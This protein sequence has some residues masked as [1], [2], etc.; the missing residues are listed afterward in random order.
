MPFVAA[1][2]VVPL[3]AGGVLAP[4]QADAQIRRSTNI[5]AG[6]FIEAPRAVRRS[7]SE[8]EK[9]IQDGNYG[10]AIIQLG[11][12][13]TGAA[14][15]A[16]IS[17]QDFILPKD[18]QATSRVIQGGMVRQVRQMIGSLPADGRRAYRERYGAEARAGLEEALAA[19]D[20]HA[21]AE[22]RRK[23]F[24]T[25]AGYRASGRLARRAWSRGRALQCSF[26]LDD[27]VT[28]PDA[29]ELL[30][31][32]VVWMHAAACAAAGREIEQPEALERHP[33]TPEMV[34]G[35]V[36]ERPKLDTAADPK[37]ALADWLRQHFAGGKLLRR[38]GIE[39]A[40]FL[41]TPD[42]NGTDSGELPLSSEEWRARTVART[43][44]EKIVNDVVQRFATMGRSP[45]PT[46]MPIA[47][48]GQVLMRTTERLVGINAENGKS[49]WSFPWQ[50][51][52]ENSMEDSSGYASE[53]DEDSGEA[54]LF[55]QRIWYD[56]PYGQ[57][58]SDGK[59]VF[60]IDGLG[61]LRSQPRNIW[62][63]RTINVR[64]EGN[65][66]V[67]LELATEGKLLWQVGRDGPESHPLQDAFF[68]GPPLQV[69]GR[70]YVL[71][72]S[73]GDIALFCLRPVDGE[74]L[75]KQDLVSVE[76]GGVAADPTRRLAG[77]IPTF[78][79]GVMI[80]PTGAGAI[81][82]LDLADRRIRWA[83]Q[84]G[85]DDMLQAYRGRQRLQPL[86][87]Y[88]S[89]WDAPVAIAQGTTVLYPSIERD[90]LYG[91]N[92]IDGKTKFP[93][94]TRNQFRYLAGMRD[95][96]FLLVSPDGVSAYDA[97]NGTRL[98]STKPAELGGGRICG[99]GVFGKNSYIIPTDAP[100]LIEVSLDD[101]VVV[102][103]R[104]TEFPLGNLIAFDGRLIAQGP[105][106]LT[107]ALG[108]A[109]L[110]PRVQKLLEISE[111]DFDALLLKS[112]LLLQRDQR[113]EAIDVLAKARALRPG[114]IVVHLRS[115]TAMLAAMRD[116]PT[117]DPELMKK[118]DSMIVQEDQRREFI[119]LRVRADLDAGQ[120][121]AAVQSLVQLAT[122]ISKKNVNETIAAGIAARGDR[123]R[124]LA[125]GQDLLSEPGDPPERGD[126][127]V[128]GDAS[129]PGDAS[130]S[131]RPSPRYR[132]LDR[133][134]TFDAWI[135]ARC[136]EAFAM[137]SS[138][139]RDAMRDELASWLAGDGASTH[140]MTLRTLGQFEAMVRDS[141]VLQ[142]AL[143][144]WS[145][146]GS[147]IQ[148]ERLIFGSRL[149]NSAGWD[150]IS[151][152]IRQRL[153]TLY[154]SLGMR[155]EADWLIQD[156]NDAG[157]SGADKSAADTE[158]V[159]D[160]TADDE[161]DADRAVV[162]LNLPGMPQVPGMPQIPG[163][164]TSR[165]WVDPYSA[166]GRTDWADTAT[167]AW[168]GG[169]KRDSFPRSSEPRL[170]DVIHQFGR[171]FAAWDSLAG[172]GLPLALRSP[173]GQMRS[174]TRSELVLNSGD[175][176]EKNGIMDGG[177]FVGR[178]GGTLVGINLYSLLSG[179]IA[180]TDTLMWSRPLGSNG[181]LVVKKTES[182]TPF[183]DAPSKYGIRG[184]EILNEGTPE[185]TFGPLLGDRFFICRGGELSAS[186]VLTGQT[187]WRVGGLPA[188]RQIVSDG[189]QVALVP[190]AAGD[191]IVFDALDG[192]LLSKHPWTGGKL[193]RTVGRYVLSYRP[194]DVDRVREIVLSDPFTRK[195]LLTHESYIIDRS[196]DETPGGFAHTI[197]GRYLV[198]FDDSGELISWDLWEG[199][200]TFRTQVDPVEKL[201][202]MHVLPMQDKLLILCRKPTTTNRI[203]SQSGLIHRMVHEI[204]AVEADS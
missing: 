202:W 188:G 65:T 47:V 24:H 148:M 204:I 93:T 173:N 192:S 176:A 199:T 81:V 91:L 193:W 76:S 41:G 63:R 11:E 40:D 123:I 51:S 71:G 124:L 85:R 121:V 165:L 34:G 149:M 6:R 168:T 38:D 140:A 119:A 87:E 66:L 200:E 111:D 1:M 133:S 143:E 195:E 70:L 80:C 61:K 147:P 37:D 113:Q 128:P 153:R 198:M 122:M 181:S 190:R 141:E 102:G 13:S 103:R 183:G 131:A 74:L 75:W 159:D 29:V 83:W 186:D 54:Q 43:Q 194:T 178:V 104:M 118:L 154:T 5:P 114:D 137:A 45:T 48:D 86:E 4:R 2:L 39:Y 125:P 69:D 127:S 115:V 53:F 95:G 144:D 187:L 59:R 174:L 15:D 94:K 184:T 78:H 162:E 98:W 152:S 14:L 22:I 191:V 167:V 155:A 50:S 132:R 79:E 182:A 64:E 109:S 26:L 120:P 10:E 175:E 52:Q 62:A 23:Y 97:N 3:I 25:D 32:G 185:L 99:R 160:A 171:S 157:K 42:R 105:K 88:L 17:G 73:S 68:L 130:A 30:G 44:Q 107:L 172:V 169:D 117:P 142:K 166:T 136:A 55:S 203:S 31:G 158:S 36:P 196:G 138:T 112:K 7:L 18:D 101:G 67:A 145:V 28:A 135:R 46:L 106:G 197:R 16:D 180:R 33:L 201:S 77:A 156:D 100:E 20:W 139:E 150:S 72:E 9:A 110:V 116:D 35:E 146:L 89:R 92:L 12:L 57:I 129:E 164:R 96:K 84:Y 60:V 163:L 179:D 177:I 108:E 21:V 151:P 126:A 49:T 27:V 8:A 161:D 134:L 170:S 90:R 56:N 58:S 19:N 82:A 189:K